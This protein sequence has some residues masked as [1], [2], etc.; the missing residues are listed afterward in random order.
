MCGLNLAW[1]A[2]RPSPSDERMIADLVEF[3]LTRRLTRLRDRD[4]GQQE[5]SRRR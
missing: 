3:L 5:G 1:L 2:I 4:W